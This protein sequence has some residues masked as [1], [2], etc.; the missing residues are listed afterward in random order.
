M[1]CEYLFMEMRKFQLDKKFCIRIVGF[2][3]RSFLFFFKKKRDRRKQNCQP[4]GKNKARILKVGP[5]GKG[6]VA[7]RGLTRHIWDTTI[8][9]H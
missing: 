7:C 4:S 2:Y 6:S 1:F 3:V 9:S 8:V 5:S